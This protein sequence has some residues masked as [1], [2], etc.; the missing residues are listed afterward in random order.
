MEQLI[1]LDSLCFRLSHLLGQFA[2]LKI[3][4][5]YRETPENRDTRSKGKLE[6]FRSTFLLA[7]ILDGIF[8]QISEPD[9][10]IDHTAVGETVH[11][12]QN[13]LP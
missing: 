7:H 13:M 8:V 5:H 6:N 2:G 11:I 12:N 1:L 3:S 10:T 4:K 9:P